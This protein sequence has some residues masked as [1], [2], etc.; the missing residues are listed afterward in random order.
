MCEM[1]GP[2]A[3][4]DWRLPRGP[5]AAPAPQRPLPARARRHPLGRWE[6]PPPGVRRAGEGKQASPPR[7][8]PRPRLPA[9]SP[10][11]GRPPARWEGRVRGR[12]LAGQAEPGRARLRAGGASFQGFLPLP[13]SRPPRSRLGAR[14]PRVR[15][16]VRRGRQCG[17][18]GASAPVRRR[19]PGVRP[20]SSAAPPPPPPPSPTG[21]DRPGAGE[22]RAARR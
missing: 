1:P 16:G 19:A 21:L 3:L 9:R 6:P 18:A 2:R 8:R 4:G 17:S 20:A 12:V 11:L 15:V 7:A 13:R 22:P 10:G 5:R 14:R